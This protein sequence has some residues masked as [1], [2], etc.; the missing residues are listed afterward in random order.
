MSIR[1]IV[2]VAAVA[3]SLA[4]PANAEEGLG[5]NT[6]FAGNIISSSEALLPEG[7]RRTPGAE[8]VSGQCTYTGQTTV[9]GQMQFQ[10]GGEAAA[11]STSQSQPELTVV[12]CT[13]VSPAQGLPGERP[14]LT[15]EFE[16]GC[17]GPVCA[18]ASTVTNWP[19]RPVVVCISG[20]AAFGPVPFVEKSIQPAC[21][22]STL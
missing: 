6:Q 14:T 20:K 5:V 4:A 10:F 18:T 9:S 3:L 22:T 12:K 7:T 1:K 2:L 16:V 11:S 8:Q 15:A 21:K 13:L 19:V 17:P